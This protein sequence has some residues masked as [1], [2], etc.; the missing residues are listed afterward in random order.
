MKSVTILMYHQVGEFRPMATHRATYCHYRSFRRQMAYLAR[1]GYA[2]IGLPEAVRGLSGE[3]DL[4]PRAVALTFDDGYANFYQYAVP[5]LARHGFP[6]T[7]FLISDMIG[8][9][10]EWLEPEG[11]A[12]ADL[13]DEKM[14]AELKR[15]GVSFAS[16]G[17]T[18]RR[19]SRLAPAEIVE[20]VAGSKIALERLLGQSVDHFCYPYG[21]YNATAV[22]AA[23]EAGYI[24][25]LTCIRGRAAPGDPLLELPRMGVSFGTTL[26]GYVWKLHLQR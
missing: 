14:I 8:G 17:R 15:E 24:A 23:R 5:E 1:M 7:V 13:M 18:H 10:A 6:S 21:D 4:P 20:E 16:H 2:V 26:P 9:R 11:L 12:A 22:E 19:L 3:S 25:A